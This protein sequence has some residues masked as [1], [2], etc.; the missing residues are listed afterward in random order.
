MKLRE[1]LNE[2]DPKGL[3]DDAKEMLSYLVH[4][5]GHVFDKHSRDRDMD[6]VLDK[7]S[8]KFDKPLY[9]GVSAA[10]LKLIE[11]GK[12]IAYYTSYSESKEVAKSF[13]T[14]V[15]ILP[16]VTGFCYWKY[17]KQVFEDLKKEDLSEY[18]SMD[19]DELL[20]T[21][22]HEKEWIF[23]I[24]IT[25]TKTGELTYTCSVPE[26]KKATQ[27]SNKSEKLS[28][29]NLK[30]GDRVSF[31]DDSLKMRT[32]EIISVTK[33]GDPI[34]N[35]KGFNFDRVHE[36]SRPGKPAYKDLLFIKADDGVIHFV[37]L[38]HFQKIKRA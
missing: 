12:P 36:D 7:L 37:M 25:F 5:K 14:V 24:G 10:E 16:P 29:S 28:A 18:K 38:F 9:R 32:G 34:P 33:E 27:A 8:E 11:S 26:R 23:D 3:S 2:S 31:N 22:L 15:T 17:Q 1:L 6:E 13:G 19:G 35:V 4:D 21:A 30:V 20:R